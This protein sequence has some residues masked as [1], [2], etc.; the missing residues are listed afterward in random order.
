[1]EFFDG[2]TCIVGPNGS[3]KSNISDAVRWVLGEQSPKTLRGGKMEEII[4]AG[5]ASRK[6]RGVAEVS[7]VI[8]NSE[9]ILPIDYQEVSIS[10]RMY[11]SGESEYA[12]NHIPCRLRD[13]KELIMDT[14]MGVEGYSIIGQGKISEIVNNKAEGRRELFE[15]AAGIVKYR[16]K[17]GEAERKMDSASGN[18]DRVNDILSEIEGRIDGLKRDSEKAREYAE[19]QAEYRTLEINVVIRQVES[20]E[21]RSKIYRDDLLEAEG[22][23][24]ALQSEKERI[25]DALNQAQGEMEKLER[26][27]VLKREELSARKEKINR[28]EN[29]ISVAKERCVSL[30]RDESRLLSEGEQIKG[31]TGEEEKYLE[32]LLEKEGGR[33]GEA[34]KQKSDYSELEAQYIEK[35]KA[36]E[37]MLSEIEERKNAVFALYNEVTAGKTEVSGLNALKGTLTKRRAQLEEQQA[38]ASD[39]EREMKSRLRSEEETRRDLFEKKGDGEVRLED[40]LEQEKEI[41]KKAAELRKQLSETQKELHQCKTKRDLLENFQQE[42]EGFSGAVKYIMSRRKSLEGI[43]G[44]VADLIEVPKGYETAIQTA[45]GA[46]VQNIVCDDDLTASRAVEM[47]KENR[48]GR[49]T[50]LPIKSIRQGKKLSENLQL[51]NIRDREGFL[52]FASELVHY[53]ERYEG[54]ITY[55]LGRIVVVDNL[56]NAVM[57]SKE[58]RQGIRFVT[59][60]GEDINP[61]GAITGG[62]LKNN[63]FNVLQRKNEMKELTE[64]VHKLAFREDSVRQ[65][66]SNQEEEREALASDISLLKERIAGWEKAFIGLDAEKKRWEGELDILKN[67]VVSWDRELSDIVSQEASAD[68]MARKLLEEVDAKSGRI[69]EEEASVEGSMKRYE[70]LR[71]ESEL[72]QNALNRQ[73]MELNAFEREGVYLLEEIQRSREGLIRLEQEHT[74]KQKALAE[75]SARKLELEQQLQQDQSLL[76]ELA[77]EWKT[78]ETYGDQ[79]EKDRLKKSEEV[80]T[81]SMRREKNDQENLRLQGEKHE[82]DLKLAK[83]DAQVD[84]LKNKLWDN[85]EVA[86]I[87]ALSMRQEKLAL[88]TAMNRS[89]ALRNRMRELE[90][91]NMGAIAEYEA[92]SQRY[93]FLKQQK[94][95][96]TAA[97]DS[98]R[99]IIDDMDRTMKSSF[100]DS[101]QKIS[102]EFRNAFT[103]L[104]GGG[105]AELQL[106]NR[107]SP[108]ESSI[109]IIARPPGKKL[110]N[111]NLLSGGEKTLTAIA[112]MCAILKV[113]PTPFCILDEVEAAL[114]DAN[115]ARFIQ[116]LRAFDGVQFLLVTHQKATM[117][118]A[119]VMYGITMPEQGISKAISLK[120]SDIDSFS[121]QL[122]KDA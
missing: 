54:I 3:G 72:L 114:D 26:E 74:V 110:Q 94:E 50:F 99:V 45:L 28:L 55:L 92:V 46:S 113:R 49:G 18:L 77:H 25:E 9:R 97:I 7:L 59:L 73:K 64:R 11:R 89:R 65:E 27:T 87:N 22:R 20:L 66:L 115:I 15:A 79:L 14:G 43:H 6:P 39:R 12:I 30:Q 70:D 117:E 76:E 24:G 19:I 108:L 100:Q 119:D 90:P 80:K 121:R 68:R 93:E 4:F 86:Y 96:L 116:Y 8:D 69:A 33:K 71:K 120:L 109:E 36:A 105:T 106:E 67:S 23:L 107:E 81:L 111:I 31:K 35:S 104:F 21:E 88:S 98:L 78:Q 84:S 58:F 16:T 10:R 34:S 57:L 48:A 83:Q 2:I 1:M 63:H 40:L 102:D 32:M 103:E 53:H 101:F 62:R 17:K 122:E 44:V 29:Q 112:L 52:G 85:F 37:A 56:K 41:E 38:A 82:L 95:D 75:V 5:T 51:L 91:V 42:Y 118:H 60:E 61:S 47:L 13:I